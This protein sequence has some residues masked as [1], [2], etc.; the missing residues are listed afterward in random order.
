L[1]DDSAPEKSAEDFD[2][3][4]AEQAR[5]WQRDHGSA[6]YRLAAEASSTLLGAILGSALAVVLIVA[7]VVGSYIGRERAVVVFVIMAVVSSVAGLYFWWRYSRD[8]RALREFDR[9]NPRD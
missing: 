7:S 1:S 8:A 6:R 4:A 3:A 9:A 2:W 5:Q